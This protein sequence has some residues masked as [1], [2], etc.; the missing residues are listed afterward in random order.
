MF[1]SA[2]GVLLLVTIT[3]V[4]CE[5]LE[6]P[7]VTLKNSWNCKRRTAND[8]VNK[9]RPNVAKLARVWQEDIKTFPDNVRFTEIG[10][11]KPGCYK[12]TTKVLVKKPIQK[13]WFRTLIRLGDLKSQ[14]IPCTKTNAELVDPKTCEK[15][16]GSCVWC[17][18]CDKVKATVGSAKACPLATKTYELE[19]E[20]CFPKAAEFTQA[21]PEKVQKI[22]ELTQKNDAGKIV[23]K[24]VFII[25][26]I[27][28]S[29]IYTPCGSLANPDD[30]PDEYL[31]KM[32]GCVISS[33]Q[34]KMKTIKELKL[35]AAP[36]RTVPH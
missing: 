34:V 2:T 13:L 20:F 35:I 1:A 19:Q 25:V 5:E 33:A 11:D 10:P 31:T 22:L 17:N 6:F 12:F 18:G 29:D 9:N 23:T 3:L 28:D 24:D 36:T 32:K 4:V 14:P 16:W 27:F 15:G 26:E 8:T 7:K 21:V 30:C